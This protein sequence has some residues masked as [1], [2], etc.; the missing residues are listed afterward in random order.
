MHQPDLPSFPPETEDAAPAL[1][2]P[3][4][5]AISFTPTGSTGPDAAAF[6]RASSPISYLASTHPPLSLAPNP[7]GTPSQPPTAAQPVPTSGQQPA[8][9]FGP[10]PTAKGGEASQS[11]AA[12]ISS[13]PANGT[14]VAGGSHGTHQPSA[15]AIS[16]AQSLLGQVASTSQ[17]QQPSQVTAAEFLS[18][19]RGAGTPGPSIPGIM[20]GPTLQQGPA[21]ATLSASQPVSAPQSTGPARDQSTGGPSFASS[22]ANGPANPFA[23]P[24]G[25]QSAAGFS[26]GPATAAAGGPP[27]GFTFGSAPAPGSSPAAANAQQGA[28]MGSAASSVAS[29]AAF[30]FG[31]TGRGFQAA[32][33]KFT[34]MSAL[35]LIA[36]V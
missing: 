6:P 22:T 27:G 30:T 28:G 35:V 19:T 20:N 23:G 12:Q 33:S 31:S 18:A 7:L 34:R 29:G 17:Q 13:Q 14:A 36:V 2:Q 16:A 1:P 24:G 4:A 15:S 10:A 32:L 21:I 5:S 9:T 25:G 8:F 11:A 3:S 26:F